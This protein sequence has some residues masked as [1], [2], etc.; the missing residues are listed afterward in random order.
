MAA[1]PV[2]VGRGRVS[3]GEHDQRRRLFFADRGKGVVEDVIGDAT[4]LGDALGLVE[5]PVDAEVNAALAIFF[6]SLGKGG[7]AA[8]HVG[9][10]VAVVVFG[11]AVEFVG[12]KRESDGIGAKETAHGLK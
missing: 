11:V 12:H 3:S 5:R 10:Q 8:R 1:N 2:E 9:T 6:L 7:E 4:A